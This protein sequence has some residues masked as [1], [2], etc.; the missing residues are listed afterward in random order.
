MFDD[1]A[2]GGGVLV[3]L[4]VVGVDV[5]VDV[6]EVEVVAVEVVVDVDEIRR[7]WC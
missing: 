5:D 2:V 1:D 4:G 3:L 6:V 7:V